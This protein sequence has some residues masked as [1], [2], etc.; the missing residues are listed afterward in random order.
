MKG[1]PNMG[2]WG[3]LRGWHSRNTS[4]GTRG[5]IDMRRVKGALIP[6]L[7]L[8]EMSPHGQVA[9]MDGCMRGD[10]KLSHHI[11][12]PQKRAVASAEFQG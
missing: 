3:A 10:S 2:N 5:F 8:V 12:G 1:L 4:L 7:L 9:M 6:S 11:E